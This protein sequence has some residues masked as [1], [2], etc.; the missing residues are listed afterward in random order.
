MKLLLASLLIVAPMMA[1]SMD[2]TPDASFYK[3]AAE[4]GMSEV[5]VG[6]LAQGK[7]A[8]QQVKDFGAMMVKD[9]GAA[10]EK[11]QAL[12]ASKNVT[13]PSSPSMGQKA[14]STELNMLSGETFDKSYI[15]S[16]LKAHRQA[17]ALFKKE[18]ATGSDADA[19]AFATAALP[20]L[21]AHLKAIKL[22][23]AAA[24]VTA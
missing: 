20:T 14:K 8:S 17:I 4:G 23:A 5:E 21:R 22:I 10:N 2:A 19:Q 1:F 15:E 7:A 12:A 9:H 11:L 3:N 24:G 18:I 6:K 16:Q 13:L